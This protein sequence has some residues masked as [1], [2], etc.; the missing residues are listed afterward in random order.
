MSMG[1]GDIPPQWVS[2]FGTPTRQTSVSVSPAPTPTTTIL[3]VFQLPSNPPRGQT[4]MLHP[5]P[6]WDF[7]HL[8]PHRPTLHIYG[9]TWQGEG[10]IWNNKYLILV[11]WLIFCWSKSLCKVFSVVLLSSTSFH[12]RHYWIILVSYYLLLY[13]C[14]VQKKTPLWTFSCVEFLVLID[15]HVFAVFVH[16][17]LLNGTFLYFVFAPLCC[18]LERKKNC[19]FRSSVTLKSHL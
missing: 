5:S 15:S 7:P 9:V 19:M 1:E 10:F 16:V 13:V 17:A 4:A 2:E 6:I 14:V 12:S 3:L 18:C 8:T 11:E